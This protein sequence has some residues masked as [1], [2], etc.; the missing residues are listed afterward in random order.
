M[1]SDADTVFG[2]SLWRNE[3][4]ETDIFLLFDGCY[5]S[6]VILVYARYSIRSSAITTFSHMFI[7]N[8]NRYTGK[9]R[10]L[11][12]GESKKQYTRLVFV[13]EKASFEYPPDLKR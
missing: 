9:H 10:K 5:L 11:F 2:E 13:L 4:L 7:A 3:T 8:K 1:D 6:A 12:I